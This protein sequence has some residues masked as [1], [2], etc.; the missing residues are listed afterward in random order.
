MEYTTGEFA[1]EKA[2][3]ETDDGP[4][5]KLEAIIQRLE[6]FI[7]SSEAFLRSS[8]IH[9]QNRR[10]QYLELN[11]RIVIEVLLEFDSLPVCGDEELRKRKK[12]VIDSVQKLLDQLEEANKKPLINTKENGRS[13]GKDR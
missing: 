8:N 4:E 13:F 6:D 5:K 12:N 2:H 11:E 1:D 3:G 10:K 7:P 9:P